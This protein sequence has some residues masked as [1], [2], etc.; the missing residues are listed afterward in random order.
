MK[1]ITTEQFDHVKLC[2]SAKLKASQTANITKLSYATV[3][4]IYSVD[5]F[6]A[7]RVLIKSLAPK[8]AK[9]VEPPQKVV[10]DEPPRQ[11]TVDEVAQFLRNIEENYRQINSRLKWLEENVDQYLRA[12]G[13][14]RSNS[15]QK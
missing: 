9:A 2:Q 11:F 15:W 12:P 3:S 13:S 6:E 1:R 14:S 8:S 10:T 7:Y 5:T 4:R